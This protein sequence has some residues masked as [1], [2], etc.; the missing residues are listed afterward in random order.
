MRM[1]A[2]RTMGALSVLLGCAMASSFAQS[3]DTKALASLPKQ[4]SATA[5]GQAGPVAGKSFEITIYIT[6]WTSN[7]Q[8]SADLSVL[9]EKGPDALV[10]AMDKHEEVGRLAPTGYTG[11]S[12]RFAQIKPTGDGGAHMVLATNRPM[13]FG[14]LYNQ[15]RSTDYPFTIL[16]LDVDKNGKGTG[17]LVPV[18]KVRF[19]KS[20]MLEIE[21]FG[22]QP[23]RLA[24]VF[25]QK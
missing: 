1:K 14:E 22:E 12:L 24:N 6:G 5:F 15:T 20:G 13:A 3:G 7:D 2:I 9:K 17:T 16:T 4:Y 25:L 18:A 10:S 8:L 19:D 11:I 23:L 21:N